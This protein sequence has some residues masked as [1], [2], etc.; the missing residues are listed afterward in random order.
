MAKKAP[1][2]NSPGNVDPVAAAT[3]AGVIYQAKLL[4]RQAKINV[5]EQELVAEVINI[6]R[7]V[8]DALS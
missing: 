1:S 5:P 7:T 6:W 8:M 3:L 2:P 4:N